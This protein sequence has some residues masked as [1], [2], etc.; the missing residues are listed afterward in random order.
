MSAY[1][2]TE[3]AVKRIESGAYDVI[4]LKLCQLRHGGPHRRV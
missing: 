1:Q 4:I 2:V 3:E